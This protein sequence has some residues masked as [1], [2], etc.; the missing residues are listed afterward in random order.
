VE[1][2]QGA[3]AGAYP[4]QCRT[5]AAGCTADQHG[6]YTAEAIA[7][8]R[9]IGALLR[10]MKAVVEEQELLQAFS[11]LAQ[12]VMCCHF[13]RLTKRAHLKL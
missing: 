2:G 3:G 11:V 13:G 12:N 10:A 5:A 1:R 6:R 8:R 9:E 4:R 7:N